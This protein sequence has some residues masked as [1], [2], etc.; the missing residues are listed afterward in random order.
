VYLLKDVT[1]QTDI[2]QGKRNQVSDAT[3]DVLKKLSGPVTVTAYANPRDPALG[4]TWLQIREFMRPYQLAKPDIALNFV[5]TTRSPKE[6]AAANIRSPRELVIEYQGRS[7]HFTSFNEQD[8]ANLLQRLMRSRERLIMYLD[9]HGEPSLE[10]SRNYDLGE[11]GAQLRSKGFR[12]Q[13]LNL[14]IA[15]E[16]PDNCSVLVLTQPRTAM[17]KGEVDKIQRFLDKGGSLFWLLDEGPLHGLEPIAQALRLELPRGIVIDPAGQELAGNAAVAVGVANG[18]HPA[19]ASGSLITVFPLA[20]PLVMASDSKPWRVTPL[21]EVARRG[22]VETGNLDKPQFDQGRETAGPV[23]VMA[24]LEREI[25]SKT[26]RVMVS[27]ASSFLSNTYLGN[28]GNLDLGV[29]SLNWLSADEG[30]IT[31]QPRARQDSEL[32]L[33]RTDLAIMVAVFLFL[34]PAL[35]L[36]AGGMIWW[37]RRKA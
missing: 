25:G 28:V 3:R 23:I 17:L 18:E 37:R 9:G 35:F 11:F 30:L 4:D 20:R 19:G 7:E 6:T 10:G 16:V 1:L 13:A 8:L 33:T 14:T 27:G 34:L 26:Q 22:W 5:D 31:V 15:P 12:L 2:T 21:V 29:N 24:A 32:R 36:F